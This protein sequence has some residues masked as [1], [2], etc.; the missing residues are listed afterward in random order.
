VLNERITLPIIAGIILILA[1][2]ALTRQH[3]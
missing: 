2:V 1:G 3:K